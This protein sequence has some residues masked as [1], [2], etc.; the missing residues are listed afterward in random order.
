[1][2]MDLNMHTHN[3]YM[4]LYE[5]SVEIMYYS[6]YT[7][8]QRLTRSFLLI[9]ALKAYYVPFVGVLQQRH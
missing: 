8:T 5:G 9:L 2:I 1:M 4:H 7:E 3:V 6:T